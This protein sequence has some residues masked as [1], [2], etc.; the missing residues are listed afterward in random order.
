MA[1][2]RSKAAFGGLIIGGALGLGLAVPARAGNGDGLAAYDRGDYALAYSELAPA[3]A[4]GDPVAQYTIARMYFTGTGVSRDIGEGLRWLRKAASAGVGSAQYQLGAHYE[5][6]IDVPQDYGEAARWY[7]MA[8]D[9]GVAEAQFRLG[10][11]YIAGNGVTADLV[12][13]H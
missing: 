8:A 13:A 2:R 6:G 11:L 10:L 7:R 12:T 1:V 3:A 4:A 9:R 5:W